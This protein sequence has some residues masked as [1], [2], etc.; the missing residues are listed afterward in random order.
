MRLFVAVNPGDEDKSEIR[1]ATAGLR[2]RDYPLRWVDTAAMHLT[3]SF[4]G[5]VVEERVKEVL[6]AI[7]GVAEK[8]SPFTIRFRGAGAFPNVRR[9]RVLW[10]GVADDG[11]LAGLQ[12]DTGT[13]LERLGFPRDRRE[14][15]PHLTL[16]RAR[17]DARPA[18]F[19]DLAAGIAAIEF[20]RALEVESIDL[21]RSH[22]SRSGA[23][24]EL[25]AASPLAAKPSIDAGGT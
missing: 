12:A 7:E 16:A 8:H 24:Y 4:L 9:P 22:L 18:A 20:E 15:S 19:S 1:A 25:L 6:S 2:A 21:M 14:Y 5:E 17:D 23:R 11:S 13:A 3:L 10:L